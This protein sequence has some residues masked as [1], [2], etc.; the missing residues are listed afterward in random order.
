MSAS[1]EVRNA[2]CLLGGHRVHV[3][4][5]PTCKMDVF[6][7]SFSSSTSVS[8]FSPLGVAGPLNNGLAVIMT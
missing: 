4:V 1:D 8:S 2:V 6:C 3:H 5:A 7:F